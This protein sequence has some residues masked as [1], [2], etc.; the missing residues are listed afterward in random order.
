M[1]PTL[2][3]FLKDWYLLISTNSAFIKYLSQFIPFCCTDLNAST[4]KEMFSWSCQPWNPSVSLVLCVVLT[5]FQEVPALLV[6]QHKRTATFV[7]HSWVILLTPACI[8]ATVDVSCVCVNMDL[9]PQTWCWMCLLCFLQ[10]VLTVVWESSS[11]EKV[12][13]CTRLPSISSPLCYLMTPNWRTKL[14]W[15]PCGE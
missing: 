1:T 11:T 12:S 3:F 5:V 13:P 14:H 15:G 7:I 8:K 10:L 2:S 6:T 4:N 9:C